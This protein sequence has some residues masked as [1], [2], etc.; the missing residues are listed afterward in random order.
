MDH[1]GRSYHGRIRSSGLKPQ[2]VRVTIDPLCE[3]AERFSF[4][5]F[6]LKFGR[7]GVLARATSAQQA[8]GRAVLHALNLE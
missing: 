3:H 7:V 5:R 2:R 1:F 6:S 4:V 8:P